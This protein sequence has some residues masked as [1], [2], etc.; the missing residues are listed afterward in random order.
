MIV[1]IQPAE[2]AQIQ[3]IQK[4]QDYHAFSLGVLEWEF[5]K[6]RAALLDVAGKPDLEKLGALQWERDTKQAFWYEKIV[7]TEDAQRQAGEASLRAAGIDPDSGEFTISEGVVMVLQR[8]SWFP[9]EQ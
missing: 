1:K 8:G 7:Q 4:R 6:H 2:W 9:F 3:E 5:L